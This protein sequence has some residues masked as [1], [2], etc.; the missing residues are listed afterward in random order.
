[1][2]HLYI[3]LCPSLV[4]LPSQII[5]LFFSVS[6]ESP[7]AHAASH[8]CGYLPVLGQWKALEGYLRGS[9]SDCNSV[10]IELRSHWT[11]PLRLRLPSGET[12]PQLFPLT[13][14][15]RE[16]IASRCC[17]RLGCLIILCLTSQQFYNLC[18]QFHHVLSSLFWSPQTQCWYGTETGSR[19]EATFGTL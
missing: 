9:I 19:R 17:S 18:N 3:C 12:S 11:E 10:S 6:R 16:V 2:G 7:P 1:M 4:S 13:H 14:H 8:V 5:P 15:G